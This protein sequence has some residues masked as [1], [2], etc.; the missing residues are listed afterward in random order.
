MA[1]I[2]GTGA[3]TG[4]QP[5]SFPLEVAC[6]NCNSLNSS[7]ASKGNQKLKIN[8][9]TKSGTDVILLSDLRLSNKN[10]I[11]CSEEVKKMFLLNKY[12]SYELLHNSSLNKRGVG[13]LL[14]KK[15]SFS[16]Q[17]IIVDPEEN[18]LLIRIEIAGEQIVLGSIYGPNNYHP[19]FL[20]I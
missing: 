19:D 1:N 15:L 6:I 12:D 17:S 14:N 4:T 20:L 7:I 10:R 3:G 11:L 5:F 16:L 8:G 18:F 9:I 2:P 13:I